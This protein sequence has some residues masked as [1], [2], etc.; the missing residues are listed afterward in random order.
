MKNTTATPPVPEKRPITRTHH[1]DTTSDDYDWLRDKNL[2]EVIAH[3]EAENAYADARTAHLGAVREA[4]VEEIRGYTKETDMS[5]PSLRGDW[6]YITRTAEGENYPTFSRV[7]NNGERPVPQPGVMLE[8]EQM[9]LDCP[10]LAEG[11]QF[12]QLNGIQPSPSQRLLAYG[13][14]TSGGERYDLRVLDVGSGEVIDDAVRETGSGIAFSADETTVFYAR[15]NDAW[16]QHQVWAHRVGTSADEDRLVF[17]DENE[18]FGVYFSTSRDGKYLVIETVSTTS[19]ECHLLS[20]TEPDAKPRCVQPRRPGLEYTVEVAGDELLIVH[21]ADNRGFALSHAPVTGGEWQPLFEAS[22][23]ERLMYVAAFADAAVVQLRSGGLSSLRVLP[24]REGKWD[25]SALWDVPRTG[26]LD[27]LELAS[28]Y[29]YETETVRFTRTS[30]LTPDTVCEVALANHEVEVLKQTE[31]PG[32][33]PSLYVERREW[34]TAADGTRIPLSVAHR[35]D[36]QPDGTNPGYLYGYGSYEISID[37][38]FS[39]M[40]LP[41]LDRGVVFAIAHV[42][43]GGEMGRDWYEGGKLLNK[44]NTFSDFVACAHHLFETGLVQQGRLAAEGGSAGGLL[45]G[46]VTN[47]APEAFRAVL[48][49][50]PF[51]DA[52]N[53]ILDPSLPLT[54]GE[55]EEWGNPL[56]DPEVYRYMKEYSP[57]ENIRPV[58]YP[59]IMAATSLNDI[60]VFYVEPAKWVARLRETVTSD[61]AERPIIFR[62]EM[63]AGH[64]GRSGRY[65][66]WEQRADQLAFMLDQIGATEKPA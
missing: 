15:V 55:W 50:V 8:G 63:V 51:V 18:S 56:A 38:S 64:G 6:W 39:A 5:V 65:N 1:G 13:V 7:K 12:F 11:E 47:L 58:E 4:I 31:V 37:P 41:L 42:R 20:L 33:D 3:L 66:K 24:R 22:D 40:R 60:R 21:N 28:N 35:R 52:L 30:L 44:K 54:V 23:G 36:V 14:D 46:A 9:L 32:Y 29:N 10:K 57:V 34:A 26:E 62:C 48:A 27:T 19:T 49:Q 16:R 2:P 61:Q 59:A 17:E 43:G 25:T 45:M 53:T